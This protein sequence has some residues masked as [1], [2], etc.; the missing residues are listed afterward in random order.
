MHESLDIIWGST[1]A[2]DVSET[3]SN[4]DRSSQLGTFTAWFPQPS[5]GAGSGLDVS[6]DPRAERASVD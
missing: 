6:E 4:N 3:G 5:G 2:T 1:G